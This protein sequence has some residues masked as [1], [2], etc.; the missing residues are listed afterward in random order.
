MLFC[1]LFCGRAAVYERA[2]LVSEIDRPRVVVHS[3]AQSG[4]VSRCAPRTDPR[5]NDLLL[6]RV[7]EQGTS[8]NDIKG[9]PEKEKKKKEQADA[10]QHA[11]EAALH[12]RFH[13]FYWCLIEGKRTHVVITASVLFC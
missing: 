12:P 1:R 11:A 4:Y 5:Y 8:G 3:R 13:F 7:R 9:G 2:L 10:T 6:R